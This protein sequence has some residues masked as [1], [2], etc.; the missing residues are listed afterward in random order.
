MTELLYQKDSYLKEFDAK[1]LE[2]KG[3]SILLDRTAFH[4]LSGGLDSDK[5]VIKY[6]G[7]EYNVVHVYLESEDSVWHDLGIASELGAGYI[8]KGV[9]DWERRYKIMKLHTASHILSSIM[10]NKYGALVTGGHIDDEHAKDDFSLES[11][12][13]SIFEEAV[14]EVNKIIQKCLDVKIYFLDR[15]EALK[16][17]GVIKLAQRSPP[18]MKYLRIVDISGVDIQADGG[19]HVRNTGEIGGIV[20]EKV[21]NKGRARKRLYYRLKE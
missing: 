18:N 5:G 4:P 16:I 1:I 8:V 15:E 20:L 12:E 10:F 6:N 11:S 7:S 19:P 14:G 17:P 3:N 21:E 2:I 9:I 13:R